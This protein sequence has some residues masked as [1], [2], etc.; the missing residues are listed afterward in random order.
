MT[1]GVA[2]LGSTGSIG[3]S[4]LDVVSRHSDRFHVVALSAR[5]SVERIYEQCVRFSPQ[6][7]AMSDEAAAE[8]LDHRI[9]HAGLDIEVLSGEQGIKSIACGPAE[10]IINGI[11]GAAGLQPVI[12]AARSGKRQLLANKEPLVM[13]GEYIVHLAR[14][15]GSLLLPVD[16]EHN[17]IFQCLPRTG[18]LEKLG[19]PR[20][21]NEMGVRKILLTGSGGPLRTIDLDIMSE[22]TPEQAIAH[23]NWDMG[24]KIS[25]DS[26]TMMN[27]ALELIEVCCL[28]GVSHKQVEIVIHPQSI[29][30]SM[31]EYLDGS[32]I[33]Q[34]GRPDM[35]IPIANALGWPERIES[36]V[37]APVFSEIAGFDFTR[38]DP[39]RF[40]A[41]RLAREVAE[42]GGTA[43]T[44]MNAANEI[45][46][47]AFLDYKIRFDE[48][49]N[50]VE[51]AVENAS[52][53]DQVD[54]ERSL[55]AD[56]EARAFCQSM[57]QKRSMTSQPS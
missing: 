48:I 38:P 15:H 31:V 10:S 11:V 29:I 53:D 32:V 13:L 54:L 9:R 21:T 7:V 18:S 36:G 57:L 39:V 56:S 45:A 19:S 52:I 26:A 42:R 25:V 47:D 27:K 37:D 28:F 46:V 12:T 41:L 40:P 35:R 4:A 43:P 30:H 20:I 8:V 16:S 5:N 44:V 6:T 2:I 50:M 22:V 14:E 24:K 49:V 33:A 51:V 3:Q 23:P 1:I 55:K 34:M 17:A